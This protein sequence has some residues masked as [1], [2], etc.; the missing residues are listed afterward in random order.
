[1]ADDSLIETVNPQS[2]LVGCAQRLY[3]SAYQHQLGIIMSMSIVF[4][5][6]PN[7]G[8]CI[9]LLANN[10][11]IVPVPKMPIVVDTGVFLLAGKYA[12]AQTHRADFKSGVAIIGCNITGVH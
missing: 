11:S 1:M 12:I 5:D 8:S 9:S 6:G 4:I 10:R 3:G 7:N 2:K